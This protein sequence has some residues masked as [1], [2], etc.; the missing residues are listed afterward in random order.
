MSAKRERLSAQRMTKDALSTRLALSERNDFQKKV[1]KLYLS[2]FIK[3]FETLISII[4][5]QVDI[6][7]CNDYEASST[8]Y[9][10]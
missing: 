7:Q 2:P 10:A 4:Q 9:N 3:K 6:P 5:K 8:L 1:S